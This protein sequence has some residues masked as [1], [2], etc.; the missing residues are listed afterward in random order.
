MF[1]YY[2]AFQNLSIPESFRVAIKTRRELPTPDELKVKL[3]DEFQAR[4]RNKDEKSKAMV[5][6]KSSRNFKN[7][8]QEYKSSD[9]GSEQRFKYR[10]HRCGKI[11]HMSKDCKWRKSQITT[12]TQTERR[13]RN[14]LNETMKAEVAA[15][16]TLNQENKWCLDSGSTSYEF[17][18]GKI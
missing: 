1:Y 17:L 15:K 7:K 2:P 16:A 3:L 14:K 10:C 18:R 6:S 11:G 9:K 4:K 5:A 13:R 12:K 8:N